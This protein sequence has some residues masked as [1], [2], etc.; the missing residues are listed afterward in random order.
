MKK[1]VKGLWSSKVIL[2]FIALF[3]STS[4]FAQQ[5]PITGKVTQD[6]GETLPGVTVVVK[7]T[8]QGTVTDIDGVYKLNAGSDAT[9]VFTFVG[10]TSQEVA[11]NGQQNIDVTLATDVIGL[12]EVVAI[13]YG[14]VKKRDITGSVASIGADKL[15]AAPIVSIDKGMQ[16]KLA[17]VTV[18][19]QSGAPGQKMKL[20]VR[21]G[22]SINYNNEPLYV[23]D[24]FIGA[25]ITTVNPQDVASID[26]LKDAS[27][28][29]I[30][31]SRGANGVVLITTKSPAKGKMQ[32]TFDANVGVT[33]TVQPYETLTPGELARLRNEYDV[34]RGSQN[35]SFT[36]AEIAEF[37]NGKGTDWLNDVTRTGVVQNYSLNITGGNEK[38][39][40]LFS[41]GYVDEQGVIL[42]SYRKL[43]SVRSNIDAKIFDWLDMKFNTYAT[44][45]SNMHNGQTYRAIS[46]AFG[47][48]ILWDSKDE[49]GEYIDPNTQPSYGIYGAASTNPIQRIETTANGENLNEKITSTIDF[50][51]KLTPHLT[52]LVSGSGMYRSGFSG[53]RQEYEPVENTRDAMTASQ[54]Y[55]RGHS[56]MTTDMLTYKN[57]F[58][59]H[60]LTASAAYE[61]SYSRSQSSSITIGDLS[62]LGNE[63]YLLS[64]GEVSRAVSTF[65][66]TKMQSYMG[67]VNYDYKGKYLLTAT[68]RADGAS[69]FSEDNRWG[70]FPSAAFAW[71]LM[72]EDFIKDT[73]WIYDLKLRAGWGQTGNRA[74]GAYATQPTLDFTTSKFLYYPFNGT[75]VSQGII[76]GAL[77][78]P[79]IQWETTVQSNIGVDFSI[80]GG[81]LSMVADWYSKT[82]KDVI[83]QKS[84]PRYTGKQSLTG[85][86]AEI[87]N[88][89]FE[90]SA[91]YHIV[92]KDDFQW[93]AFANISVNRNEVMDLGG[94]EQIFIAGEDAFSIWGIDNKF[95]VREGESLGS[96]WGLQNEGLWQTGEEDQAAVYNS[97]PGEP[98]YTDLPDADGN[99]GKIDATDRMIIGNA[100][101]DFTY[102]IGTDLYYKSFDLT[103]QGHGSHGNDVFNYNRQRMDD[104]EVRFLNPDYLNRWSP[105]NTGS[106]QQKLPTGTEYYKT[107]VTSQYIEDASF[108]KISNITLGYTLPDQIAKSLSLAKFRI[109]ASVNNVLTI[110]NYSGLDPEMSAT[111]QGSD[112]VSGID[113]YSY[114]LARTWTFGLKVNF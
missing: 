76:S 57:S 97:K 87:K 85:N 81:K 113:A 41:A 31:G 54:G 55:S 66:E 2:A 8:S 64:N 11:V 67:R 3:L 14:T 60:T 44:H 37:D 46:D 98:K 110:T 23:I 4:V 70:Y 58:G 74:I 71:R 62:T 94:D 56:L 79:N 53:N 39:G 50:S 82:S 27:A 84:I 16:G 26:I 65:S 91:D 103:I 40:Y 19:Q 93:N 35:L 83:L 90:F 17:G 25:D 63:W 48:P 21:G 100:L 73:E 88:T 68:M 101:P 20:R 18:Q 5:I 109:Y 105:T 47:Y 61:Y 45:S 72:E 92:N 102:G 86:F 6:G 49:N 80:L 112:A 15:T 89:G 30:Y 114:P 75:T 43:Y 107:H 51:A 59:D 108:F 7:G 32:V 104:S 12:E 78:D 13:G 33:S 52:L 24:G 22:G 36:D 28:T 69:V 99:T 1:K 10:F 9:L 38:L 29:A 106:T 77:T 96:F 42:E 95:V 34:E 111:T